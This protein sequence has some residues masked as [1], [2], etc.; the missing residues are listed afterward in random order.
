MPQLRWGCDGWVA[1]GKAYPVPYTVTMKGAGPYSSVSPWEWSASVDGSG[2][3]RRLPSLPRTSTY[4]L[5][6]VLFIP[7]LTSCIERLWQT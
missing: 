6:V 1:G 2:Q 7:F 4:N 3:V 5:S